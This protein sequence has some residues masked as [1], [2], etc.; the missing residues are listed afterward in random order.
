[1][2]RVPFIASALATLLVHAPIAAQSGGFVVTLGRDTIQV[3]TFTRS[4]SAVEGTVVYRSPSARVVK[5]RLQ[6]DGEGQP[7]EYWQNIFSPDG[8][9]LEPNNGNATMM[10]A[11][12]TITRETTR[13]AELVKQQI[14]APNGAVPLLGSSL[15]IPFAYSYLTYELAFARA[16]AATTRGETRWYLL[17][18]SPGQ[19]AP[20]AL[21]VWHIAEDSVEADYFGVARSG[22]KF[23][24]AG[25]LIRSDWTATTYKYIVTR[26]G[27]FAVEP[28][29]KR[30]AAEDAAGRGLVN[31][32]PRDTA[33]ANI[34]GANVWVDYS[35]PSARGRSIWG[36][37]VPWNE[38]WR[39]GANFAT[40]LKTEADL[41]IGGTRLPTGIYSLWLL[42][43]AEQSLLIVN[44]QSGQ[45]GTQYD[46]RQ[47]LVRLPVQR[48]TLAQPAEQLTIGLTGGLLRI[49]WA[50]LRHTIPL[51]KQ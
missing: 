40:Q 25:H 10:F 26:V 44:K 4:G 15:M 5:Y 48:S 35:R 16:R 36:G 1:M 24:R 45:F 46:A 49:D 27:A 8:H 11:G 47:D 13:Q 29:A 22:F 31:Y 12:D 17:G 2:R 50:D 41:L 51:K 20:Q 33:R 34:D 30:W 3:E 19:T 21:R 7:G 6:L 39:L 42:P 28:F 18:N 37:V 43:S 32:S 38:V 9:K 14:A 23:D